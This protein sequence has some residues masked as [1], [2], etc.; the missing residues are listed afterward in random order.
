[1]A[2][3]GAAGSESLVVGCVFE[4]NWADINGGAMAVLDTSGA[5]RDRVEDSSFRANTAA[6]AGGAVYLAFASQTRFVRTVFEPAGFG[7]EEGN[8]GGFGGAVRADSTVVGRRG[9]V[10]TKTG[11]ED[12][13]SQVTNY[14][15]LLAAAGD[16]DPCFA[17]MVEAREPR[18]NFPCF[19]DLA[20]RG[21]PA[22]GSDHR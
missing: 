3:E 5:A 22:L 11:S 16:L 13:R 2:V 1:M 19:D 7:G 8:T 12:L 14:A 10:L 21:C 20:F 4:Y 18:P 15:D 17:A 6:D 9:E